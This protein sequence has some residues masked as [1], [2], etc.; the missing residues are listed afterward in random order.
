[1]N[2]ETDNKETLL[3]Q[4]TIYMSLT[5]FCIRKKLSSFVQ[6]GSRFWLLNLYVGVFIVEATISWTKRCTRENSADTKSMTGRL[7]APS[8]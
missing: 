4:F 6:G 7:I 3:K 5:H 8:L 1:M 2:L